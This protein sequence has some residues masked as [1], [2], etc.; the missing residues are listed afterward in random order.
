MSARVVVALGDDLRRRIL[1]ERDLDR[2][3]AAADVV[4]SLDPALFATADA[5]VT[6]W[7]TPPLPPSSY[8][9]GARL[10]L[11]AHTGGSVRH[12]VPAVALDRGVRVTQVAAVLAEAVAEFAVMSIIAGLRDAA[13][14]ATALR[15]GAPWADLAAR[16]PGRLLRDQTVGIVGASRTGRA[17]LHRLRPFG[18]RCLMYDP[19]LS[20][21]DAAALGAEPAGLPRLLRESDVV[22]LHAPVLPSTRGMIGAAEIAA[23]RPGALVVNTARAALADGAALLAAAAAGRIRVVTDVFDTEPL[24]VDDPWRRA[25]GVVATPHIAALTAETLREQGAVTVDEVLRFLDGRPLV[26]EITRAAY[27]TS[28]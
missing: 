27:D 3:A 13:G 22:S 10:R 21:E 25:G 23:L 20:A 17:T 11:V 26:H 15:S 14:F 18:C 4:L 16:P 7:D 2:L 8:A 24:P 6:G 1:A 28:A 19:Y 5:C 9:D 12:L